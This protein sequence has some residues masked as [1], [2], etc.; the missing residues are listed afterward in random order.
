MRARVCALPT[1]EA[2]PNPPRWN[3]NHAEAANVAI[4]LLGSQ[5]LA[6]DEDELSTFRSSLNA[7]RRN[8]LYPERR[9]ESMV[10]QARSGSDG[11]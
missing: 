1:I 4:R 10:V 6:Y 2:H 8:K 5:K 9:A 7:V 11:V 3:R